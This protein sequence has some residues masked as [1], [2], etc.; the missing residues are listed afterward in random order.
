MKYRQ[1]FECKKDLPFAV[2][3]G[4]AACPFC[5]AVNEPV[6]PMESIDRSNARKRSRGALAEGGVIGVM[7]ST[8]L[9]GG[10]GGC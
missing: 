3:D 5:G 2:G 4:S 6:E 9:G 7:I 1:C 10:S 8:I